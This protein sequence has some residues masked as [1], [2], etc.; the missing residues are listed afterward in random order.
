[1]LCIVEIAMSVFGII[2]LVKGTIAF[3]RSRVVTGAPAYIN[4]YAP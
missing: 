3:S 1:M 4:P 2:T